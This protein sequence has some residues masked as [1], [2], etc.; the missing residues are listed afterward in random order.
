MRNDFLNAL[1]MCLIVTLYTTRISESNPYM[2]SEEAA[3]DLI[4]L[5]EAGKNKETPSNGSVPVIA[6]ES[7]DKSSK[8][9]ER[10]KPALLVGPG[11]NGDSEVNTGAEVGNSE[12]EYIE[13][14][15]LNDVEDV[16][17]SL[18]VLQFVVYLFTFFIL[19]TKLYFQCLC[20]SFFI[21]RH[22]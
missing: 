18:K 5:P 22:C 3:S 6:V 10:G 17:T 2:M 9:K 8:D 4:A 11:L 15:N 7:V 13:S 21:Y 14:E 12:V 19:V 16:D 1:L 20:V